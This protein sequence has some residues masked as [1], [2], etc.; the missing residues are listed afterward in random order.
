MKTQL[1]AIAAIVAFGST[2]ALA[3]T[4]EHN[5]FRHTVQ[6]ES[7]DNLLV[8]KASD[9][10]R[11]NANRY[12]LQ[13]NLNNLALVQVQESLLGKHYRYQQMHQGLPIDQAEVIVSLDNNGRVLK[14]FNNSVPV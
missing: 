2:A 4:I 12:G 7:F 13:A 3:R 8:N 9:V 10:L 5:D 14:V 11:T 6:F 1:T